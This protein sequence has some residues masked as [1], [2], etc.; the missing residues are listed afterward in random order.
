MGLAKWLIK[1]GIGSPGQTAKVWTKEF[2]KAP[3]TEDI[4]DVFERM[5]MAFQFGQ[6]Q[7]G[8]LV[9]QTD[10]EKLVEYSNECLAT[11]IFTM[12]CETKGFVE[13]IKVL[14][15][16]H[17]VTEAIYET[18]Y[19][20]APHA[21]N[22]ELGNYKDVC[23]VYINY[24]GKNDSLLQ[25]EGR[26]AQM[27][28]RYDKIISVWGDNPESLITKQ[29]RDKIIITR[30]FYNKITSTI[31]ILELFDKVEVEF[32]VS[33]GTDCTTEKM[34]FPTGTNQILILNSLIRKSNK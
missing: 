23:A 30:K 29:K 1:K 18:V 34:L 21:I 11:L 16:F 6:S 10:T 28:D 31:S 9:R 26:L 5:A 14:N 2:L 27:E 7:V 20:L 32:S 15:N 4:N 25:W 33:H 13:N 3:D 17:M 8:N 24:N 12:L 19:E 22:L